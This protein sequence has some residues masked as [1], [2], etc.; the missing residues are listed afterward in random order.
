MSGRAFSKSKP[1]PAKQAAPTAAKKDNL[2]NPADYRKH[3]NKYLNRKMLI[4]N[5]ISQIEES[6]IKNSDPV[7]PYGAPAKTFELFHMMKNITQRFCPDE[8]VSTEW[9]DLAINLFYILHKGNVYQ[10]EEILSQEEYEWIKNILTTCVAAVEKIELTSRRTEP[11]TDYKN[12]SFTIDQ[13]CSGGKV[14][15]KYMLFYENIMQC[16]FTLFRRPQDIATA[17][18]TKVVIIDQ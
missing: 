8:Y 11:P 16:N 9:L 13:D 2:T 18:Q 1:S 12:S 15:I 4:Y 14:Y 6:P 7:P 5:I 17:H 10:Y 3:D